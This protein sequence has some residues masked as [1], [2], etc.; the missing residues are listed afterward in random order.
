MSGQSKREVKA[1]SEMS[2]VI[3]HE[4]S[5]SSSQ[6]K[7]V[8]KFVDDKGMNSSESAKFL[9]FLFCHTR[10]SSFGRHELPDYMNEIWANKAFLP[11]MHPLLAKESSMNNQAKKEVQRFINKK[12]G[13]K[14]C[15]IDEFLSLV[16]AQTR[17][18]GVANRYTVSDMVKHIW[19]KQIVYKNK[20]AA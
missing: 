6:K 4:G 16:F 18:Y 2:T 5:L 3:L 14:P 1:K 19:K 20:A 8:Q 15:V 13:V 10:K 12:C 17:K 7:V 11:A 9:D